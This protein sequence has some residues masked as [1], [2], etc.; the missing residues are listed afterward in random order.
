MIYEH[1]LTQ[2]LQMGKALSG[3]TP[4]LTSEGF[5]SMEE[6]KMGDHVYT[7]NGTLTKV[8][9]KTDCLMDRE[10]YDVTFDNG[11]T[12]I[13]DSEHL[14]NVIDPEY[15]E[16][17]TMV[18]YMIHDRAIEHNKDGNHITIRKSTKIYFE[19]HRVEIS[20]NEF[21]FTDDIPDEYIFNDETIRLDTLS[22]I[23]KEDTIIS[24]HDSSFINKAKTLLST[25]GMSYVE[26]KTD[27]V[28]I[29]TLSD[30]HVH[31]IVNVKRRESVPVYCIEVDN[32]THLFLAGNTLIPTHNCVMGDTMITIRNKN[33]G[34]VKSVSINDFHED[35]I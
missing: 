34:E 19:H 2:P 23:L 10:V 30:N 9:G 27:G 16:P 14:W 24:H 29:L 32:P 4:I 1:N 15:P 17:V 21:E 6:I 22:K 12:I 3:D 8:L 18:T 28:T 33:T 13:A 11:E 35:N 5:K 25:L 7:E 20:P 26:H 31:T